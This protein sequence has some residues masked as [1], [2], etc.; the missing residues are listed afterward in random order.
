MNKVQAQEVI[1]QI[2]RMNLMSVGARDF[3]LTTEGKLS[4]RIMI[5][6]NVRHWIVVELTAADDYTVELK[7]Q[8]RNGSIVTT[9]K[10]EGIY[11]DQIGEAVYRLGS[12]KG[13]GD[14]W[15]RAVGITKVAA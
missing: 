14:E 12:L 2:G 15:S 10:A 3:G 9:M 7:T 5:N 11:C 1:S 8:K 4:F 6:R 13:Q